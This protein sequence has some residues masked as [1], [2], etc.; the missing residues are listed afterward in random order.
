MNTADAIEAI[1][2]GDYYALI[3]ALDV[4]KRDTVDM[5]PV[6][7]PVVTVAL[8]G[9][10][11]YQVSP[12]DGNVPGVAMITAIPEGIDPT[13]AFYQAMARGQETVQEARDA[14]RVTAGSALPM[15]FTTV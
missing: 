8:I 13:Y 15:G 4:D 7:G 11:L 2:A 12:A 9:R 10:S 1:K 14:L 5:T 3:N 6:G